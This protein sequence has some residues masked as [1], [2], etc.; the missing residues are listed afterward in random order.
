MSEKYRN[1]RCLAFY[2]CYDRLL[3]NYMSHMHFFLFLQEQFKL[4]TNVKIAY[5]EIICILLDYFERKEDK[6]NYMATV[7]LNDSAAV[8]K[9]IFGYCY[10]EYYGEKYPNKIDAVKERIRC[11][12]KCYEIFGKLGTYQRRAKPD[13]KK[14]LVIEEFQFVQAY[15]K[16]MYEQKNLESIDYFKRFLFIYR[17]SEESQDSDNENSE[18][19][20]QRK[21]FLEILKKDKDA[22]T[23]EIK[24]A[25]D[26]Y[27]EQLK[28]VSFGQLSE[29]DKS[30]FFK[31]LFVAFGNTKS[32]KTGGLKGNIVQIKNLLFLG[33]YYNIHTLP[34]EYIQWKNGDIKFQKMISLLAYATWR[35]YRRLPPLFDLS[36]AKSK[37]K[38]GRK[39][40]APDTSIQKEK[41]RHIEISEILKQESY[42]NQFIQ[43]D[44]RSPDLKIEK[45]I[46]HISMPSFV[47]MRAK[48]VSKK[49]A[50]SKLMINI[51]DS[52]G[53]TAIIG[54]KEKRELYTYLN[55]M[56]N[57]DCIESSISNY[58]FFR[59]FMLKKSGI[60]FFTHY[61]IY[62]LCTIDTKEIQ[63]LFKGFVQTLPCE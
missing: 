1:A 9:E 39:S 43:S 10:R 34:L 21:N 26:W 27:K 54:D 7:I 17:F 35:D 58:M 37:R 32:P 6:E 46:E 18:W 5:K 62:N 57:N 42:G 52:S 4:I 24:K 51:F 50:L 45:L 23:A 53:L 14:D 8:Y 55:K 38:E 49:E 25:R 47:D 13:R 20:E 59:E 31:E 3:K 16:F 60:P 11:N 63:D 12:D 30:S 33:R 40:V 56:G 48:N 41:A 61:D 44:M 28:K 29:K 36:M 22:T 2:A 19:H 15:S